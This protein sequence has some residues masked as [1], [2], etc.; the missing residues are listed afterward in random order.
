MVETRPTFGVP[1]TKFVNIVYGKQ[2][3][4]VFLENPVGAGLISKSQL[5]DE[6]STVFGL[7]PNQKRTIFL[8]AQLKQEISDNLAALSG[9][10]VY[11]SHETSRMTLSGDEGASFCRFV[12]L[13][14]SGKKATLLL[15]NPSGCDVTQ[16]AVQV[17]F[18]EIFKCFQFLGLQSGHSYGPVCSDLNSHV[19]KRL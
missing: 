5:V 2:V 6:V 4:V 14:H 7:D 19:T 1:I 11:V 9:K 12:E 3:G 8:D 15:E 16:Y 17:K 10:I 13:E 18:G